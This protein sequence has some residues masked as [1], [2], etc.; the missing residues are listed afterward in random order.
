MKSIVLI[1]DSIRIGYQD[2]VKRELA[3]RA[4][5]WGPE[6]NGGTSRN[7]LMHLSDW[8]IARSPDIVHLNCGLHDLRREPGSSGTFVPVE[9]YGKNLRNIFRT[10]RDSLDTVL[11][12]ALTTPVNQEDHHTNKPFD[13][14]E[15]DVNLFNRKA[16]EVSQEYGIPVNNLFNVIEG[17]GTESCLMPDGVHFTD[18]G[19]SLLGRAVADF[20]SGYL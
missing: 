2:T 19:Y 20:L 18:E 10:V 13:R 17:K 16:L 14:F 12:F 4:D 3:G 1:G 8:V 11:I 7:V 15:T 6:E 5:V 9:E